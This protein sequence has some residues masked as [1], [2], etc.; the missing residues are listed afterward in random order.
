MCVANT[1]THFYGRPTF[2]CTY[3]FAVYK[4]LPQCLQ[5]YLMF[6]VIRMYNIGLVHLSIRYLCIYFIFLH[7]HLNCS[8][9]QIFR[10]GKAKKLF[11]DRIHMMKLFIAFLSFARLHF[12]F[13]CHVS[14]AP[15]VISDVI[16][17]I[18]TQEKFVE[19]KN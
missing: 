16:K 2:H 13:N 17:K 19:N 7:L 14:H 11:P 1:F 9:I 6:R 12:C 10:K 4:W 8:F 3:I 15:N 5:K 18:L